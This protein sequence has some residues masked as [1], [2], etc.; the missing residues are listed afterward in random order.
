MSEE[1]IRFVI[2]EMRVQISYLEKILELRLE[3]EKLGKSLKSVDDV[4]SPLIRKATIPVEGIIK[5]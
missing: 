1:D 4:L 3:A 2:T 5:R